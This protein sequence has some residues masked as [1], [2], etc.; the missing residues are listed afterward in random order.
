MQQLK[1]GQYWINIPAINPFC[2]AITNFFTSQQTFTVK[3]DCLRYELNSFMFQQLLFNN[4]MAM[5]IHSLCTKMTQGSLD[6]FLPNT[7]YLKSNLHWGWLCLTFACKISACKNYAVVKCLN[8]QCHA[9]RCFLYQGDLDSRQK[10][11]V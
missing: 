11:L 9:F 1:C 10:W 7:R 6:T 2:L 4:C 8:Y 5:L 3:I